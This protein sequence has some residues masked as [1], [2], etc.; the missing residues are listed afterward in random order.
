MVQPIYEQLHKA[1]HV[2][3]YGAGGYGQRAVARFSIIPLRNVIDGVVVTHK[4]GHQNK[5]SDYDIYEIADIDTPKGTTLFVIAVSEK[6]Q[7]EIIQILTDRGYLNFIT[8]N[9][10][11]KNRKN[12]YYFANHTFID[13]RRNS[14]KAC[15]VLSGYKEFLWDNVFERLLMFVP[16]D[17]DVCLLSSGLFSQRLNEIARKNEWSY[18]STEVN[19]I[20]LI[21]NIAYGLFEEA[22]WVYKM[23]EDI[24]L[25]ENCFERLMVTYRMVEK[26]EPYRVGFAAPLIPINGYGYIRILNRLNKLE[27]YENR[28][29]RAIYGGNPEGM[30]ES[31]VET[32]KYLWGVDGNVPGIDVLNSVVGE[33]TGYSV[34]G[35]RFS[36]GF[37]L[38]KRQLWED[39]DGFYVSGKLDIGVDERAICSYCIIKSRAMIVAENVV[40]G[41]F[42]FGK[43]TE[44][45]K[46]VYMD[47][48]ELFQIEENS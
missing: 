7:G 12:I 20:G 22:E 6:F 43:Q 1:Q 3:I 8:W 23:D 39:M 32:A 21:Q 48:P 30:L 44:G 29:G 40:V 9:E 42:S 38:F 33:D 14:G 10:L 26:K 47:H 4:S 13:R 37:I 27:E 35:V 46:Q 24:F 5:V 28:F 19:D 45:M 2:W 34:C 15:F 25:T 31:N 16:D 18:L 17:V 41:H 36:I 11:N